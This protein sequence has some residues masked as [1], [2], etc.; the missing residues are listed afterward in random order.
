MSAGRKPLK[1]PEADDSGATFNEQGFGDGLATMRTVVPQEQLEAMTEV[2]SLGK[3]VGS[4]LTAK[5]VGNFCAAAQIRAFEEINKSKAFKYLRIN[6]PD[7]SCAVA[8][9]IDEFCKA[10]FGLGYRAMSDHKLMME[11]LGEES[12]ENAN[13]LGLNRSQ[14][15]L[16]INL[17]EDT[18]SAVEEAMHS[19]SKSEVVTLIQSL[20]NQLD[21]SKAKEEDLNGEIVAK[22][23][24]LEKRFGKIEELEKELDRRQNLP[25][26]EALIE[27]RQ[28]ATKEFGLVKATIMTVLR[29]VVIK[30]ND[31]HEIN[32]GDSAMF[33]AGLAGDVQKELTIMRDELGVENI[34]PSMIPEYLN[35][36]RFNELNAVV[37]DPSKH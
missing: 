12:Y 28:L 19:S 20:A 3:A 26:D 29:S 25:A 10:V 32:G 33:L 4:V 8:Q 9:N 7:G 16:L 37:T 23:R 13:R 21:E 15:R 36:P 11:R 6:M 22:E 14:L 31:H 2:F 24:L 5:V 1:Q 17:P 35:D 18:R 34:N 27:L 30:I